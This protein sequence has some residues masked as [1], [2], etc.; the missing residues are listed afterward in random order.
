MQVR[1]NGEHQKLDVAQNAAITGA[2]EPI[3]SASC[4]KKD[5]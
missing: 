1:E 2:L 5:S 3:N 4:K